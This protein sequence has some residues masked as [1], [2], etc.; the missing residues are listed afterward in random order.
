LAGRNFAAEPGGIQPLHGIRSRT[1]LY[2]LLYPLAEPLLP[3]IR[4]LFPNTVL[5]T[6]GIGHAMLEIARKGAPK[7]ILEI[8]DIEKIGGA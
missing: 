8:V 6:E 7:P 4:R 5:T 1:R 2:R 3:L